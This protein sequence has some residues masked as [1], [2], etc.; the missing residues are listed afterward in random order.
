[1]Y[2]AQYF[3]SRCERCLEGAEYPGK[4]AQCVPPQ[5]TSRRCQKHPCGVYPADLSTPNQPAPANACRLALICGQTVFGGL[6]LGSQCLRGGCLW[7]L[8]DQHPQDA[9]WCTNFRS[10]CCPSRRGSWICVAQATVVH[11]LEMTPG[12]CCCFVRRFH[13]PASMSASCA[14]VVFD[15]C[16][17][18]SRVSGPSAAVD[19]D[20]LAPAQ[21]AGRACPP[22]R[23]PR[24]SGAWGSAVS[25]TGSVHRLPSLSWRW[26]CGARS[27]STADTARPALPASERPGAGRTPEAGA[28]NRRQ[29]V[30]GPACL[31]L[32][33]ES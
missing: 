14:P 22:S 10:S 28:G 2:L 4:P 6:G 32:S 20:S 30:A 25:P 12:S 33:A 3:H 29:Q 27:S 13:P 1:M 9:C 21:G 26:R 17:A 7:Q 5:L 24:G 19:G 31:P 15:A 23:L 11:L 8:H 16:P 18:M